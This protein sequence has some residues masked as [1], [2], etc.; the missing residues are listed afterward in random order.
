MKIKLFNSPI[1]RQA[2]HP[3]LPTE[4]NSPEL[5]DLIKG[6]TETMYAEE[7]IGLAANQIGSDKSICIMDSSEPDAE[8]LRNKPRVFINPII[9]S[10]SAEY[11]MVEESC[12]S[13]PGVFAQTERFKAVT[14]KY[15]TVD[16]HLVEESLEGIE[17]IAMQHEVDHLNGKLYTDMLGPVKR[18]LIL[19][20]SQK[21]VK[22]KTRGVI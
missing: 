9:V 17:A 4:F 7:G 5:N 22:A 6:M 13:I 2:A 1:L 15:N 16:G 3:V 11:T 10:A 8:G 18:N 19:S 20:R 14:V 21:Y 12:L